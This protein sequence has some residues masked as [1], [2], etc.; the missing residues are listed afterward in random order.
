MKFSGV[1]ETIFQVR[2]HFCSLLCIS[3]GTVRKLRDKCTS[4]A[5]QVFSIH[6]L[7][8]SICLLIFHYS[9]WLFD[10]EFEISACLKNIICVFQNA[11]FRFAAFRITKF[12]AFRSAEREWKCVLYENKY[13]GFQ[14][15]CRWGFCE[16]F[17]HTGSISWGDK[18]RLLHVKSLISFLFT[19]F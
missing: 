4:P 5:K 2:K 16:E 17:S 6:F 3:M 19:R 15:S 8:R 12:W 18:Y 9:L 10:C 13:G 1:F 14:F 11:K 7:F